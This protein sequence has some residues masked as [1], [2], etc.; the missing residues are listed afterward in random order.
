[1]S[2]KRK[3]EELKRQ[4]EEAIIEIDH[5]QR[6]IRNKKEYANRSSIEKYADTIAN[7]EMLEKFG[8]KTTELGPNIVIPRQSKKGGKNKTNKQKNKQSKQNK[9]S[10]Y[11]R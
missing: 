7:R 1:M 4:L 9:K 2:E 5:L 8:L 10:R 3:M 6:E 11:N